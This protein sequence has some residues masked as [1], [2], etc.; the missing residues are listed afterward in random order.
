[1]NVISYSAN[2]LSN[3]IFYCAIRLKDTSQIPK[4]SPFDLITSELMPPKTMSANNLF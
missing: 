3:I 2:L 1:M 4:K